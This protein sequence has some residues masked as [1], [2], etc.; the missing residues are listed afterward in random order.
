MAGIL[1]LSDQKVKTITIK[2]LRALKDKVESMQ[3][4]WAIYAER[5]QSYERAKIRKKHARDQRHC[6]K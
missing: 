1:E 4:R 2:I 5:W 6:N 3:D